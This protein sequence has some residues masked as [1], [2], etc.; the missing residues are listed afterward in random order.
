MHRVFRVIYEA[1]IQTPREYLAPITGAWR[2]IKREYRHLD[3]LEARKL[4]TGRNLLR[5]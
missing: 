2:G 1:A 3:L 5:R 4:R